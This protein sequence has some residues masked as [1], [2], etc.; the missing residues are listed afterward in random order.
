[1]NGNEIFRF[2]E[3]KKKLL[4]FLAGMAGNVN[5]AA[6]II[7][8]NQR[9]SAEHVIQHA[10]DSFFVPG[11]DAGRQDNGVVFLDGNEAMVVHGDAG[12]GG[13]RFGLG[14]GREDEELAWLVAANVLRTDNGA[15]R[16]LEAIEVVRDFNIVHH[17]AADKGDFAADTLSYVDYLL[18]PVN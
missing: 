15:I 14:A 7:V 8:I 6:R 10:E 9:T 16:D 13:H 2:D 3:L 5:H 4:F 11:N 12:K 17:A 18:N 1:M